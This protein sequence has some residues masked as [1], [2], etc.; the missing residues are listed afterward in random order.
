M[1]LLLMALAG[2]AG[3]GTRFLVDGLVHQWVERAAFPLGTLL[4]NATGSFLLGLL[5]GAVL[6][7]QAAP[8]LQ[9][10][11]GTGFLGGYTTFSTASVDTVRLVQRARWGSA[12]ANALGTILLTAVA[13]AAGLALAA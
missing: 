1:T 7:H 12:L 5:T 8:E 2:G 10:I 6:S 13:C 11:L 9:L 4:V 3:A